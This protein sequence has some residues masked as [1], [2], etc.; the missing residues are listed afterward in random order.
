MEK[1]FPH[2]HIYEEELVA[3]GKVVKSQGTRG[4]VRV[5][6][7]TD[8]PHRFDDL[9]EAYLTGG[10]KE[11][12]KVCL[13]KVRHQRGMIIIKFR[14]VETRGESQA[15]VGKMLQ[16]ERKDLI[17]L[18]ESSYYIFQIVGLKVVTEEGNLIG[19]VE[20]VLKFPG[21]D[22]YLVKGEEYETW[23]PAVKEIVRQIDLEGRKMVIR[24]IP[25][26]LE[27]HRPH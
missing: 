6:P 13:E 8:F 10:N 12:L 15:L 14:G 20:E 9:K 1:E 16:L 27:L 22:I 3:I 5:L 4:E 23:I 21:Q 17:P 18:K 24:P 7:L 2:P 19:E 11:C 25:G 26:L